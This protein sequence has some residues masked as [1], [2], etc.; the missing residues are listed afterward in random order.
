MSEPLSEHSGPVSCVAFS[1][2]S[3]MLASASS[4]GTVRFW[5][6]PPGHP[7]SLESRASI[8]RPPDVHR[9]S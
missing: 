2:D 6:M 5:E 8:D 9:G 7:L 3:A 1:P 4:D